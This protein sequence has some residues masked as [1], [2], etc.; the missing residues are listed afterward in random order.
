[1]T[2]LRFKHEPSSRATV[3]AL[4]GHA[5]VYPTVHVLQLL[6]QFYYNGS[7]IFK[8]L[9]TIFKISSYA[10]VHTSISLQCLSHF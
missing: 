8:I 10:T 4:H 1:M 9:S 5:T 3:H 7:V 6:S 2:K